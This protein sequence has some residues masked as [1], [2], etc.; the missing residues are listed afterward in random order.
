MSLIVSTAYMDE[1][2]GF[3]WLI[4]MNGGSHSWCGYSRPISWRKPARRRWKP[5]T[6]RCCPNADGREDADEI[7]IPPRADDDGEP[8]IAAKGLTRRFGRFHRR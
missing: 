8:A 2:E 1:A 5:P 3:D 4:A 6:F 7:V